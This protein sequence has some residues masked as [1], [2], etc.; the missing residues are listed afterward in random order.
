MAYTEI[1]ASKI[2]VGK[3]VIKSLW[4]IIRDNF[5]SH[6]TRISVGEGAVNKMI[7]I[8]Q[9]ID[10]A[11]IPRA[12]EIRS[13]LMTSAQISARLEADYWELI[14]GQSVSGKT[15]ASIYGATLPDARNRFLRNLASSGK[16]IGQLEANLFS[17]HNHDGDHNHILQT[18]NS[19]STYTKTG[20]KVGDFMA[21]DTTGTSVRVIGTTLFSDSTTF[22]IKW[23]RTTD[24]GTISSNQ[25]G[26]ENRPDSF[27]VNNAIKEHEDFSQLAVVRVPSNCN[28]VSA[29]ISSLKVAG[30]SGNLEIDLLK[31]SSLASVSSMLTTNISL[32]S[33]SGANATSSEGSFSDNTLLQ[34]DF[35]VVELKSL[36]NQQTRFHISIYGEA[37]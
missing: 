2:E 32:P 19:D 37:S 14:T 11:M 13:Y 18:G 33:T 3:P 1:D 31:G 7:L 8:D 15:L 21:H 26:A 30:D 27:I 35:L 4:E 23:D 28:I 10:M 34:N 20:V 25:G 17:S 36:Q 24:S 12:G 16:T 5:I 29:T 6:E 9:V 22:N